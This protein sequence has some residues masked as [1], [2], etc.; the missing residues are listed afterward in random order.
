MGFGN[1][2]ESIHAAIH[3]IMA[4]AAVDMQVN[5]AGDYVP[6]GGI[7]YLGFRYLNVSFRNI[8]YPS[9]NHQQGTVPNL[10]V[11]GEEGAVYN[12]NGF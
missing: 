4:A 6:A 7:E 8:G 12:L 10:A 5:E 2:Q 3:K 11:R 1:A 9:V